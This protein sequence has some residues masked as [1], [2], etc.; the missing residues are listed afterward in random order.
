MLRVAV[1]LTL[2]CAVGAFAQTPDT[3]TVQGLVTDPSHAVVPGV[4][5]TVKNVRI[6]LTRSVKTDDSGKFS[7]AGGLAGAYNQRLR[8]QGI[9]R[10]QSAE[11]FRLCGT[12][13]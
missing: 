13:P 5:L 11:P 7:V 1:W 8:H 4:H 6:G 12:T 10:K 2:V 3:A 9:A